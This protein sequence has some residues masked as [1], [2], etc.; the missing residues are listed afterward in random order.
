MFFLCVCRKKLIRSIVVIFYF[1]HMKHWLQYL[2]PKEL[3]RTG[4][5]FL[6]FFL[7]L[8]IWYVVYLFL[9]SV[10]ELWSFI[11]IFLYSLLLLIPLII[12]LNFRWKKWIIL[13]V[14]FCLFGGFWGKT[15]DVFMTP[16]K[17]TTQLTSVFLDGATPVTIS[18]WFFFSER[19]FI[20]M[21]SNF[22]LGKT[23][24]GRD[25]ELHNHINS[26]YDL[27][28]QDPI[29]SLVKSEYI[30][31]FDS[32]LQ[33]PHA[34]EHYYRYIPK[35]WWD[36]RLVVFIHGSAGNFMMYPWMFR[37]L[38]EQSDS[39]MAYVSYK[40]WDWQ[41][42]DGVDTIKRVIDWELSHWKINHPH[43][44]TAPEI[45]LVAL[46]RWWTGLTRFIAKYPKIAKY[47]VPI[48]AVLEQN[49][50]NTSEFKKGLSS[51]KVYI[52]HGMKDVNVPIEWA[53]NLERIAQELAIPTRTSYD[54][55]GDHFMAFDIQKTIDATL[56]EI[57]Q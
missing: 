26:Q 7:T 30:S 21:W 2:R 28:K 41:E 43:T 17:N 12:F 39:T 38:S 46:S 23:P 8:P 40:F 56:M 50:M 3:I 34:G 36:K 24:Q 10:K 22:L 35:N 11:G 52:V 18:P 57:W 48:S 32:I 45:T 4:L 1:F 44:K 5:L 55:E 20:R 16:Q 37:S 13:G 29:F 27:M 14:T 25:G 9:F 6:Y 54:K 51:T 15:I 47:I 19:D 42:S 53:Y 33:I 31:A 49:I